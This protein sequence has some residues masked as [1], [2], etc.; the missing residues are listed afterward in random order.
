[1]AL[2]SSVSASAADWQSKVAE[3]RASC[4]KAIPEAWT[5]PHSLLE[6]LPLPS[7][8]SKTKVNLVS[9]DIPRR[10]GILT[11]RELEI[12]GSYNV[13]CL[14]ED[15]ASGKLTAYEVTLAFSKRA[16]IA[17]QLVSLFPKASPP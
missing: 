6:S 12:T 7:Y 5:L 11:E 3:K 2:Q 8:L 13:P 10:S 16:A 4:Q 9:L 15:I 1:M 17:Q 14:L